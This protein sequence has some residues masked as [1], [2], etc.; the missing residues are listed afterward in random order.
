MP[1]APHLGPAGHDGTVM[2]ASRPETGPVA[3]V[4]AGYRLVAWIR[5]SEAD[6]ALAAHELRRDI[7]VRRH[8]RGRV[9][10]GALPRGRQPRSQEVPI[11]RPDPARRFHE[12]RAHSRLA[13]ACGGGR[14]SPGGTGGPRRPC[15]RGWTHRGF[16]AQYFERESPEAT[17]FRSTTRLLRRGGYDVVSEQE[18]AVGGLQELGSPLPVV[19]RGRWASPRPGR[20]VRGSR[21][22]RSRRRSSPRRPVGAGRGGGAGQSMKIR[23]GFLSSIEGD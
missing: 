19:E 12:R 13:Q 21:D 1:A 5:P 4:P 22:R 10:A 14:D 9:L 7:P 3:G 23:R 15:A 16:M 2:E 8:H 11:K 18:L 17:T 20:S 6:A